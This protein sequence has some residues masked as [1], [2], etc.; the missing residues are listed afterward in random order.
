M[1]TRWPVQLRY[2]AG[3]PL[4]TDA[5]LAPVLPDL[6]FPAEATP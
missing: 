3:L 1:S 5:Q 4:L 6:E 2:V